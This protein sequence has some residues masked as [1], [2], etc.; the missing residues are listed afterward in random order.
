MKAA[1]K[2]KRSMHSVMRH[3][4]A[5]AALGAIALA[6]IPLH[7]ANQTSNSSAEDGSAHARYGYIYFG[8]DNIPND[9]NNSGSSARN[10][11]ALNGD[12]VTTQLRG[13]RLIN[14]R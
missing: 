6:S 7:A 1:D 14:K 4:T 2:T 10:D 13:D 5:A 8:T 9:G 11:H 12:A 3:M